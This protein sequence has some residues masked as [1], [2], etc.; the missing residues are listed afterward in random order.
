METL[1]MNRGIMT[2][3]KFPPIFVTPESETPGG[4]FFLTS[5]DHTVPPQVQT[6]YAFRSSSETV[7]EVLKQSL[8]K[9]LVHFYPLAGALA[10]DSE[11]RFVVDCS[12]KSVAFV[13]AVADCTV[14]MIGDLRVPDE[15]TTRMLVHMDPDHYAKSLL[16]IPLLTA[17]VNFVFS[18]DHMHACIRGISNRTFEKR[19]H[20]LPVVCK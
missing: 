6:I 13:E 16:E 20:C 19:R 11:G 18:F 10:L 5:L 2:L 3:K 1:T 15:D 14:N 4:I 17:Q 8:A 7:A 12:K 9:A